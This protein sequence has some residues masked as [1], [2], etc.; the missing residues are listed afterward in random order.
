MVSTG[1]GAGYCAATSVTLICYFALI[2]K[3]VPGTMARPA[4]E[5]F[6]LQTNATMCRENNRK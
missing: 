4:G 1:G 5:K 2:V 3:P 6:H